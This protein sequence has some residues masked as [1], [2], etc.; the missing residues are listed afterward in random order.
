MYFFASMNIFGRLVRC[1]EPEF[2]VKY[3]SIKG[4]GEEHLD[5]RHVECNAG[6]RMNAAWNTANSNTFQC[7][8][9]TE[10]TIG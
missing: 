8:N 4:D 7:K 5:F 6:F 3:G 2:K 10:N 9:G 1:K